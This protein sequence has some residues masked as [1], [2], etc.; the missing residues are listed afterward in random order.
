MAQLLFQNILFA[1]I[2]RKQTVCSENVVPIM[3]WFSF[4]EPLFSSVKCTTGKPEANA[5]SMPPW[6]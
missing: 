4:A 5:A 3:E 1:Y 2:H 6:V